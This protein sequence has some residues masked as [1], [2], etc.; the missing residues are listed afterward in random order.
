MELI[1]KI[2]EI[3]KADALIDFFMPIFWVI[4][5]LFMIQG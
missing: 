1:V 3:Y 2:G 4:I 5:V